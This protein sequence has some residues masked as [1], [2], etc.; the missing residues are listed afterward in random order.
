MHVHLKVQTQ[1]C[2]KV[3]TNWIGKLSIQVHHGE[4]KGQIFYNRNSSNLTLKEVFGI[5]MAVLF[6]MP[7]S[8]ILFFRNFLAKIN[9]RLFK[10]VYDIKSI[11]PY[12]IYQYLRVSEC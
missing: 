10:M 6:Q 8:I 2:L 9:R 12:G 5:R 11:Q 7:N 1:L 4:E 3:V